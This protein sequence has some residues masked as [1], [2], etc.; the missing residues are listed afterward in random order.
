MTLSESRERYVIVEAIQHSQCEDA[1]VRY[2][3]N[4]T[5]LRGWKDIIRHT[6]VGLQCECKKGRKEESTVK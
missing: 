1:N 6:D 4:R 3:Y 2:L 5:D